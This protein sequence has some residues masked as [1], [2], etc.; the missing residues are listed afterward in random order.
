V[1]RDFGASNASS[2]VGLA[3]VVF[4]SS[5][6][7]QAFVKGDALPNSWGPGGSVSLVEGSG[8]LHSV[9]VYACVRVLA[10]TIASL[11]LLTY[12]RT[13][14]GKERASTHELYRLL[15]DQPNSEMS[16]F[17]FREA[18]VG[19]V[20][21]WGNAYAEIERDTRGR[22]VGLWLMR[23]DRM[24]IERV[25]PIGLVYHYR[26]TDGT[27]RK[28]PARQVLHIRGMGGDGIVGYSPIALAGQA[29]ALAMQTEQYGSRFFSN[30]SRPGGVLQTSGKLSD[31]ASKR[32]KE[33]WE[34]SH[35]G[36]GNAWRVAVLE[37]GLSWQ[38]IGLPPEDAQFIETRKYQ[39]SEIA[40]LFRVPA[41][42]IGDLERSTNNNIEHQSLEFVQYTLAPWLVRIEQAIHR[43]LIDEREQSTVYVEHLI[44]GLLRGDI[45]S[46][47]RAYAVGRQWGWLSADDV[48]EREN[49]NPLPD[50]TGAEYLTPVNMIPAGAYDTLRPGEPSPGGQP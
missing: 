10:E 50:G 49:M 37:E 9:P 23:P 48:R 21:L 34:A 25:D 27:T 39:L 26:L 1:H 42:L 11:P 30:D 33:S 32:L 7:T 36:G 17:E 16:A 28:L 18:L 22:I 13:P 19:H 47:Y 3:D 15:H 31:E 45:A 46:R 44:D 38:Q 14:K 41:H 20:C 40:R 24:T 5:P 12:R 2:L 8:A 35:R 29:I 4:R 6:F 43:A